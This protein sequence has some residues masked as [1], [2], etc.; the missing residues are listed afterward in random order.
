[1]HNS[2]HRWTRRLDRLIWVGLAVPAVT[3]IV[4]VTAS[5]DV[6]TTSS[7][8]SS[9]R[10]AIATQSSVHV[11]FKAHSSATS[12]TEEIIADIGKSAGSE[13]V[14]EGSADVA[15]RLTP[16]FAYVSGN[17]SGLTKIFAMSAAGAKK[18]GRDWESWKAGSA[19]YEN[20]K[21]DLTMSSVAKLLPSAKGTT[22]HSESTHGARI[23]VLKWSTGATA[24]VPKLSSTFTISAG[25]VT[26]PMTLTSTAS[27]GTSVTTTLS[28]WGEPILVQAP[29]AT[30]VISSPKVG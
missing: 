29:P 1:M 12:T 24:S 23:Y 25:H 20:L 14:S 8:L 21:S 26:L 10:S 19:Q 9:T 27:G 6:I 5:A 17:S 11:V 13:T 16:T 7:V 2:T 28:K 22:L 3:A 4:A 15:I 30:S 18:V